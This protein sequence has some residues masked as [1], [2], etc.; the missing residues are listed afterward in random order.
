MNYQNML[1]LF[2]DKW[3]ILNFIIKYHNSTS[4]GVPSIVFFLLYDELKK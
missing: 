1:E 3:L 4:C 2:A